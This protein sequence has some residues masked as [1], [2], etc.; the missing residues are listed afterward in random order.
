MIVPPKRQDAAA[1]RP[2]WRRRGWWVLVGGRGGQ[3]ATVRLLISHHIRSGL[4]PPST[5]S[6]SGL[7]G[8]TRD[9]G[10]ERRAKGEEHTGGGRE[11]TGER[12]AAFV[13]GACT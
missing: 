12:S 11:E 9:E 6:K 7:T 2:P 4:S 3:Y 13:Y 1:A 10:K 5:G 8:N